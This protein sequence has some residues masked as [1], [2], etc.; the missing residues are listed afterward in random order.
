MDS[1][2]LHEI[3]RD[4]FENGM[5]RWT[6]NSVSNRSGRE[7]ALNSSGENA[8]RGLLSSPSRKFFN[9]NEAA[10]LQLVAFYLLD[11][12]RLASV[13]DYAALVD[14]G[15]DYMQ[16]A[17]VSLEITRFCNLRCLHCYNDSGQRGPG[18]LRDQE[19]LALAD[20]LCRWGVRR[21][22]LT[23]GEPTLDPSLPG[24]LLLAHDNGVAVKVTTN[25]WALPKALL[26]AIGAG[27][28]VHVNVS[29]DGAD[30]ATHDSF[31]GRHGSYARVLRSM[32]IL[33]ECRPQV[34]QLNVSI[35]SVSVHQMD[36]LAKIAHDYLF[37]SISFKPVTSGGRS[38]GRRDFFLSPSDLQIFRT[39]RALLGARYHDHLRVEGYVLAGAA[40]ES[41]DQIGCNAADRSMLILHNGKMTPCSALNADSWVPDIRD[42]SP[43]EAWLTHPVFVG[44]RSMKRG[45]GSSHLGC[46]GARFASAVGNN[47][48]RVLQ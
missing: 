32:R 20:Y 27:T 22:S 25:G 42:M 43:M 41:L 40:P 45:V 13:I 33:A 26:A 23:G 15:L 48:L 21:I 18:E 4:A 5:L 46:P 28:V 29:L 14:Q 36:A 34:L 2:S 9:L 31:R 10:L 1:N 17:E 19:K 39:Q 44:F 6:D 8:L 16:P 38:D 37:D 24:L 12:G 11:R 30:E 3:V 35:H 47:G 7:L